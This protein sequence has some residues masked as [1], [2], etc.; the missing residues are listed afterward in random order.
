MDAGTKWSIKLTDGKTMQY[1]IIG[2]N[3][4]TWPTNPARRD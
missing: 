2:I 3:T 4:T 1:R